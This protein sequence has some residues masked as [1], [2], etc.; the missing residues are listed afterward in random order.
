MLQGIYNDLSQYSNVFFIKTPHDME[1]I[2]IYL[3]SYYVFIKTSHR[4]Q[5]AF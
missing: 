3:N 1:F 4:S 5:M 2:L